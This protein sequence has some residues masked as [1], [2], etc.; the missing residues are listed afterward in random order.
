MNLN[1]LLFILLIIT[2]FYII[3]LRYNYT[4]N[5]EERE[6]IIRRVLDGNLN[7]R[8]LSN[9]K[10]NY[11]NVNFL[12]NQLIENYQSHIIK[13]DNNEKRRK[14]LLSNISHD[15]R[16]PLTSIIGYLDAI[17]SSIAKTNK[18]KKKY[19]EIANNRSRQLKITLDD[20]FELA[21]AN[22][23][24]IVLNKRILNINSIL[25][26][27]L[28]EF[29][30]ILEEENINLINN[31]INEDVYIYADEYS[32][33][34][35]IRNLINNA[36]SHG[37]DGGIIGVDSK[38]LKK[39]YYINIWDKG[40]GIKDDIEKIFLRLHKRNLTNG[41]NSGLGLAIAKA[42]VEKND[43]SIS[44]ES[45]PNEKTSFIVSFPVIKK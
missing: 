39:R 44:V 10:S 1:V 32:I 31:I 26:D 24:E 16:T 18:E 17:E 7:S 6:I 35:V 23:N 3:N 19:L 37:K 12:I 22:S 45:I 29:I 21:K 30:P 33:K 25:T 15:I 2:I 38:I 14:E 5:E 27:T 8:L 41:K 11:S 9:D 42:L 34:R 4:K 13:M 43:G 20:I 40:V 36:I 28:I